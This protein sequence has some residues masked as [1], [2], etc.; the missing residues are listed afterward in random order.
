MSVRR[1]LQGARM[2]SIGLGTGANKGVGEEV[3]SERESPRGQVNASGSV[4]KDLMR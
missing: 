3:T 1:A 2:V 4:G